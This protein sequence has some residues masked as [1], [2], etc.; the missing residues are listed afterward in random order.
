MFA[1]SR[2]SRL[3]ALVAMAPA[4]LVLLFGIGI[5]SRW[6]GDVV[7]ALLTICTAFSLQQAIWRRRK[8]S[9]PLSEDPYSVGCIVLAATAAASIAIAGF[10]ATIVLEEAERSAGRRPYCIQSGARTAGNILDLSL[11]TFRESRYRGQNGPRF[12]RNHGLLVVDTG[13]GQ[14]VLNWSYRNLVFLPESLADHPN[15][16]T[17]PQVVCKPR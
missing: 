1:V 14:D 11:L 10:T 13:G 2:V 3:L 8:A 4:I 12:L 7:F 6:R 9:R 16:T 15:L 17:R 5:F